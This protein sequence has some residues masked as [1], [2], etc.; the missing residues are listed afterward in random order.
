MNTLHYLLLLSICSWLAGCTSPTAVRVPTDIDRVVLATGGCFGQCPFEVIDISS[1]LKVRYHGVED[2]YPLGFH[3]G[4][5]SQEFWDKLNLKFERIKFRETDEPICH[6]A[7]DLATEIFIY[8]CEQEVK[9]VIRGD[10]CLKDEV[11]A[12]Y[13]WLLNSHDSLNLV[14]TKDTLRFPTRIEI[15]LPP[16]KVEVVNFVESMNEVLK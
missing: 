10:A 6:S 4:T 12:V 14:E 7:D 16:V 1:N 9:H 15:P 2:T 5:V 3:T 11:S 13:Q 8:Y